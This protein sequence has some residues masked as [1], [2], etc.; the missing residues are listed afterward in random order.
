MAPRNPHEARITVR[1]LAYPNRE[2][3]EKAIREVDDVVFDKVRQVENNAVER[4]HRFMDAGRRSVTAASAVA[5]EIEEL[6]EEIARR[7]GPLD[8]D[9]AER[10][11]IMK[12]K[13]KAARQQL[14]RHSLEAEYHAK[15]LADPYAAYIR[16]TDRFTMLRPDVGF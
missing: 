4:A 11:E 1:L 6:R 15:T 5:N 16:M 9:M 14:N 2:A 13:A 8:P 7:Q 3:E 10:Y 12:G